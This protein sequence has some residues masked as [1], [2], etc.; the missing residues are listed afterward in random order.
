MQQCHCEVTKY[1]L[2]KVQAR[3][4][5]RS[6]HSCPFDSSSQPMREPSTR[7]RSPATMER[8]SLDNLCPLSMDTGMQAYMSMLGQKIADSMRDLIIDAYSA[9]LDRRSLRKSRC[10]HS[11]R[12]VFGDLRHPADSQNALPM[13]MP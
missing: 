11:S 12:H 8:R 4:D 2:L 10:I 5:S 9:R 6:F 13:T 7:K 1:A 3:F